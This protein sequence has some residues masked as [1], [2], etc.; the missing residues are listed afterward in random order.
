VR[1][2][3]PSQRRKA[4]IAKARFH[5]PASLVQRAAEVFSQ[6]SLSDEGREGTGSLHRKAQGALDAAVSSAKILVENRGEIACRVIAHGAP[7]WLIARG[8]YS[9]ADAKRCMSHTRRGSAHRRG[10]GHAS[11]LDI[12]AL[13]AAASAARRCVTRGLRLSVRTRRLCR[14]LRAARVVFIA[15]RRKRCARWATSSGQTPPAGRRRALRPGYVGETRAT[16]AWRRSR[17]LA[18]RCR[19]GR[20]GGGGRACVGWRSGRLAPALAGAR[21]KPRTP[22]AMPPD[23]RAPRRQR[24]P[25]RDPGLRDHHGHAVHLGERDCTRSGGARSDRRSA[26]AESSTRR[27]AK[28]W[29]TMRSRPPWP[30]AIAVAGTVEIHRR[31]SA[32]HYFLEMNTRLQVEQPGHGVASPGSISSSGSCASPPASRCR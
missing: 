30:L 16:N 12:A 32:P 13:L 11:Y 19:E 28:R 7:L 24:P 15:R 23:A 6:A 10:T 18:C 5:A 4:L 22:S 26:L 8:R 9:D 14:G 1:G 3:A 20:R 29:G 17:E 27:C 25:H 2:R 21:V 31:R